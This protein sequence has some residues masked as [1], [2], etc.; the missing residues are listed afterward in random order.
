MISANCTGSKW[1]REVEHFCHFSASTSR[2]QTV[3]PSEPLCPDPTQNSAKGALYCCAVETA[4][5]SNSDRLRAAMISPS[6]ISRSDWSRGGV[7]GKVSKKCVNSVPPEGELRLQTSS[8]SSLQAAARVWHGDAP[9]VA[10]ERRWWEWRDSGMREWYSWCSPVAPPE[11]GSIGHE[12]RDASPT[13]PIQNTCNSARPVHRAPLRT[14]LLLLLPHWCHVV[15]TAAWT[16]AGPSRDGADQSVLD[17]KEPI[18]AEYCLFYPGVPTNLWKS[19]CA[20]IHLMKR[21]SKV[22][23]NYKIT[24]HNNIGKYVCE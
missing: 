11:R 21:L 5:V 23:N 8:S 24:S 10:R 15:H 16:P 18:F 12:E 3:N 20:E 7:E 2:L 17:V 22:S 9:R 4:Q 13:S 19:R 1:A 6:P 14:P